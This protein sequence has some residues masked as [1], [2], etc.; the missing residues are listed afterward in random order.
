MTHKNDFLPVPSV[1]VSSLIVQYGNN[2]LYLQN[3]RR[4][5]AAVTIHHGL[6]TGCWI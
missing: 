6:E 1:L 5:Q 3:V 2:T 4:K